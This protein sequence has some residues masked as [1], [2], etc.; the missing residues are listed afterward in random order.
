LESNF[1]SKD[2]MSKE[3]FQTFLTE[4]R[5]GNIEL[6]ESFIEENKSFIHNAITK[7]LNMS[8]LPYNSEE[9][10]IGISAFNYSID[11]YDLTSSYDFFE[12]TERIIKSCIFDYVKSNSTKVSN[13]DQL[14]NEYLNRDSENTE[15]IS[16]FKHKLWS[17][18]ITLEDLVASSPNENQ[19]MGLS[20]DLGRKLA[21][22]DEYLKAF[23]QKGILPQEY[24]DKDPR[25]SKKFLEKCKP[26]IIALSLIESSQLIVMRSYIKN[27]ESGKRSTENSGILLEVYMENAIF[28]DI[29]GKFTISKIKNSTG[30]EIG[31]QM[32]IA[33]PEKK[34]NTNRLKY[35][36]FA[37]S[38]LFSLV[39]MFF[40]YNFM[41]AKNETINTE[42]K[43][44][45]IVTNK[46][47]PTPVIDDQP[48][49]I[50]EETVNPPTEVVSDNVSIPTPEVTKVVRK[51]PRRTSVV[52]TTKPK[53]TQVNNAVVTPSQST[54]LNTPSEALSTPTSVIETSSKPSN[55]G[56]S[57]TPITDKADGPPAKPHI[58][59]S[60]TKVKV[61]QSYTISMSMNGGNNGTLK[62][63]YENDKI[64]LF[65]REK[66]NS[67]Q[68]QS[69][70]ITIKA[71]TKGV[72]RYRS[73]LLNDKGNT[74]S[75][76]INVYVE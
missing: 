59:A 28:F 15:E 36:L 10:E 21:K 56:P 19:S 29:H 63:I 45:V 18:G 72:F 16:I 22:S 69:A 17:L 66:D 70:S 30:L 7:L 12:Y 3:N 54:D 26:Y 1:F 46:V 64:I 39:A 44:V 35:I 55:S 51:K 38:F 74:G 58:S 73:K 41:M 75:G 62:V 33:A 23:S 34:T 68:P 49:P 9:F 76:T 60:A 42:S 57:P 32:A 14:E 24:L 48:T 65:E 61:G 6:R 25:I 53:V 8:T 50:V 40:L 27:L 71:K 4:L 67:P 20:F 5:L 11:N 13:A 2:K 47:D 37:G 52:A 43:K 31:K